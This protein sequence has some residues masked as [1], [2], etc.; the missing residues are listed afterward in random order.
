[1]SRIGDIL[2]IETGKTMI[3]EPYSTT[4]VELY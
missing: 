3:K 1:M 2:K 4:F